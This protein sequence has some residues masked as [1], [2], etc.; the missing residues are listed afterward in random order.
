MTEVNNNNELDLLNELISMRENQRQNFSPEMDQVFLERANQ[1]LETL[2]QKTLYLPRGTVLKA[3]TG[4][5]FEKADSIHLLGEG[6]IFGA[7]RKAVHPEYLGGPVMF[8]P[9][10]RTL[11][12]QQFHAACRKGQATVV[13]MGDSIFATASDMVSHTENAC[14]SWLETLQ[15]CNPGVRFKFVNAALGGRNW[16][17]MNSNSHRPPEWIDAR[18]G[19]NWKEAVADLKPDLLLLNSGGND[20]G[21]FEPSAVK[22]LI[23]FFLSLE[24]AP[25]IVIGISHL[26]SLSSEIHEYGTEKFIQG[27][28]TLAKWLRTYAL[29]KGLGYLDFYRWNT[30]RRDGFDPCELSL[31]RI[32]ADPI[33]GFTGFGKPQGCADLGRWK[34]PAAQNENG[35]PAN[36]ITDFVVSFEIQERPLFLSINLSGTPVDGHKVHYANSIYIYFDN[37]EG[38]ISWSWSDGIENDHAFRVKTDIPVPSFPAKFNVMVKGNRA[39]I[40][41]W[42]PFQ[43]SNWQPGNDLVSLG[44]GYQYICDQTLVRFGGEF[45][46]HIH[47][48]GSGDIIVHN[49]C[50][51]S[52]VRV[53]GGGRRNMP[54]CTNSELFMS[55]HYA[56]GSN[57][58]HMNAYGVRDILT[59][60]IRAQEWDMKPRS[61]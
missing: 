42:V 22:E 48:A 4:F 14:F 46:P 49:L 32:D 30:I 8:P 37:E 31:S 28:D 1:L 20:V 16:S 43:N 50:I 47:W 11:H 59:P 41:V 25:S 33:E 5:S 29:S 2:G 15:E 45:C 36:S 27:F 17:D 39:V 52:A 40:S 7:M 10:V 53:N 57:H 54:D 6:K 9:T 61:L 38:T 23:G 18:A 13:V 56:G 26:P 21:K 24:K 55:T 12:L 35:L 58:Y 19:L 60:V 44:T 3:A 34:F 51:G